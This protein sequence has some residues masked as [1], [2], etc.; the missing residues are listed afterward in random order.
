MDK[1][2]SNAPAVDKEEISRWVATAE[3]NGDF[4]N[5]AG[6]R[7]A[8]RFVEGMPLQ[9]S[10]SP[11]PSTSMLSGHM[12]NVSET[13]IAFWTKKEVPARTT[14][15]VRDANTEGDGGWLQAW[16]THCTRGIRGF[17]IGAAFGG[18]PRP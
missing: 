13:G 14:I 10:M 7:A 15:Y 2:K 6:K 5:F 16:V 18:N 12:H 8:T 3:Q 4:D 9:I 1:N 17:L 11:S